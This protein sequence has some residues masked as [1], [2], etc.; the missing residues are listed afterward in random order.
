MTM[1]GYILNCDMKLELISCS[2]KR[3]TFLRNIYKKNEFAIF[4]HLITGLRYLL[5][6][7]MHK[8]LFLNLPLNFSSDNNTCPSF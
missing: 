6:Y 2:F 8:Y 4:A 5:T 1:T 3:G 7:L